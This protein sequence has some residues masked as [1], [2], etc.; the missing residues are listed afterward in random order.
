MVVGYYRDTIVFAYKGYFNRNIDYDW[1]GAILLDAR[2]VIDQCKKYNGIPP[3]PSVHYAGI[4]GLSFDKLSPTNHY[5]N[6][7]TYYK[8]E[9]V[10]PM[11]CRW[12]D[13]HLPSTI[14]NKEYETDMTMEIFVR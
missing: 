10:N 1:T 5:R 11:D 4:F 12:L 3:A 9:L 6:C 13:C 2:K 8:Y 14:S 7:N